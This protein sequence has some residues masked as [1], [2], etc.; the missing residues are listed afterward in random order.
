[1]RQGNYAY[2]LGLPEANDVSLRLRPLE[3]R[4]LEGL[5]RL[6][7]PGTMILFPHYEVFLQVTVFPLSLQDKQLVQTS[8]I[9]AKAFPRSLSQSLPHK[10]RKVFEDKMILSLL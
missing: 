3:D 2:G 1:M 5:L 6:G 7:L 4:P 9:S 10:R 8:L